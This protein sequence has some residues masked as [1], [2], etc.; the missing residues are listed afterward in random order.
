MRRLPPATILYVAHTC[1][2]LAFGASVVLIAA[3]P[4]S[5]PIRQSI[6]PFARTIERPALT[7]AIVGFRRCRQTA[8]FE[9]ALT[10][11]TLSCRRRRIEQHRL[12]A[13]LG[14]DAMTTTA[15]TFRSRRSAQGGSYDRRPP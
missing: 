8:R 9:A 12:A 4:T 7:A 1:V 2:Y 5:K 6:L 13:A 10:R 14:T 11:P 15:Q 3:Q